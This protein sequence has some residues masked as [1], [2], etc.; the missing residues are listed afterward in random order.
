M[1]ELFPRILFIFAV[2]VLS[3]AYGFFSHWK[4]IF[5]Y[6]LLHEANLAFNAIMELGNEKIE[7]KN[8]DFWDETGLTGPS[9]SSHSADTSEENIFIL[10][11]ERTYADEASVESFLAWIADRD[12]NILHAWKD[13][14]E[15]WTPLENRDAVGDAWRSYPVGAHL[16]ANGDIL[17][18]YQG[19]NVFPVPMG[20][21]RFD[22]DSN[23]L[24]KN[25]GYY[26]HW[27]SVGKDGEIYVPD[28]IIGQSPLKIDDRKK[29][30]V[31]NQA[32]FPYESVSVL[33]GS[34]NKIR[35]IDV[36]AAISNSDLAGL[37]NSNSKNAET[38][39]TC[40][41]LHL[42]DVQVLTD[43][44]A[45]EFPGFESGDL[46]L[47]F[48]SLN[49]IGVLDPDTELFKWFYVGSSQH[50]HSPR[51]RKDNQVM[52]FDNYGGR[53]SRGISRVLTVDV[54]SHQSTIAFPRVNS[55]LPEMPFFSNTAGHIDLDKS[56]DRVLVSFTHQ[57]LVWEIDI[58]SGEI[59]WQFVNTHPVQG[60]PARISVYTAKYV[61]QIAFPTNGG[62]LK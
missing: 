62:T 52:L 49:G 47:S 32:L 60:R 12:G 40:D 35:E 9:Y 15:L 42:N 61:E 53:I 5:P 37:I 22:K 1:K 21:A 28:T 24:W 17:V 51:F 31:C 2:S 59:L 57:G 30:I 6:R 33:D 26:H 55:E 23:L 29:T 13:P 10:G 4:E 18:S 41:V 44:L 8:V 20:I 11:N 45:G 38:V 7:L 54:T 58:D 19:V 25:G 36:L 16:F 43:E 46:L 27:F 50:Q 3:F 34:G 56:G 48:R 14:G 39:E